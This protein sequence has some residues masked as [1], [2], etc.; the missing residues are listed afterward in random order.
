[1]ENATYDPNLGYLAFGGIAPVKTTGSAVT[2]PVQQTTSPVAS[3]ID[4]GFFY[5]SIDIDEYIFPGSTAKGLG[6]TGAGKQAILDTGTNLNYVPTHLAKAYNAQFKP[7]AK[8]VEDEGAYYV[9][10]NATVPKFVVV[11]GGKTFTVDAKD[12]IVPSG[13]NNKGE[14]V[15]ISGTQDGG[16]PSDP[17]T[18]YTMGDVFLH[19]VVV[20]FSWLVTCA[21][22]TT[23]LSSQSTFNV[24]K[25]TV[26]LTQRAVY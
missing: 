19:N 21:S 10:C 15:C 11:I 1:M 23:V 25:N 14:E 22:L 5:Y 18:V 24:D 13:T 2:I 26:T 8:F 20:C 9:A 3:D 16:D 6:L 12:Q 17:N 4:I 7:A